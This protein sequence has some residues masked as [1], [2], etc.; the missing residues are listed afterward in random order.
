MPSESEHKAMIQ[1]LKIYLDQNVL[2]LIVKGRAPDLFEY[3]KLAD[4]YRVVYSLPTLQELERILDHEKRS[5]FLDLLNSLNAAY[6]WVDESEIAHFS[7]GN[8]HQ[9]FEEHIESNKDIKS[10]IESLKTFSHKLYGGQKDV[11]MN[12]VIEENKRSF[13]SLLDKLKAHLCIAANELNLDEKDINIWIEDYKVKFADVQHGFKKQY[14]KNSELGLND[15]ISLFREQLSLTPVQ[16]NNIKPPN[17][18]PQIVDVLKERRVSIGM[19]TSVEESMINEILKDAEGKNKSIIVQINGLYNLLNSIGYYSD[20][21]VKKWEKFNAFLSDSHHAGYAAY[22]QILM[23]A[24]K[25]FVK[26]IC[27]VYEYLGV[28]TKIYELEKI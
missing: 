27:A 10:I 9:I 21:Q 20:P 4:G 13:E 19:S 26:K 6:Y 18:I 8:S 11:P 16:L 1:E 2:D 25:R 3:L 5:K 14:E 15:G 12:S 24:D 7:L 22:S 23:S 28:T 17:I